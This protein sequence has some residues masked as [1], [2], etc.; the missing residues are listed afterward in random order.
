MKT[1]KLG[2]EVIALPVEERTRF[3]DKILKS[4]NPPDEKIDNKWIVTAHQR[5]EQLRSGKVKAV[6]GEEVFNEM[7]LMGIV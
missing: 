1:G 7:N 6:S 4:L 2:D 3:V 5:L